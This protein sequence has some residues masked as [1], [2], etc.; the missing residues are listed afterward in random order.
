MCVH[1]LVM[2]VGLHMYLIDSHFGEQKWAKKGSQD[3]FSTTSRS[4]DTGLNQS[5]THHTKQVFCPGLTVA[6][7]IIYAGEIPK[8]VYFRLYKT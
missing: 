3:W 5:Y 6:T 7:C 4:M 8:L 2:V 1:A